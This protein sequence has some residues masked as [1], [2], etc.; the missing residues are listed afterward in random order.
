MLA[1][2]DKM[3]KFVKER[4]KALESYSVPELEKFIKKWHKEMYPSFKDAKPIVKRATL[5][6]MICNSEDFA[7]TE[8]EKRAAKWLRLV[9]M[10]KKMFFE[11]TEY[12][13]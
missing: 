13:K 8:L 5:C 12:G 4:H 7:G 6:K 3:S 1:H 10:R 11:D 9:G 2:M